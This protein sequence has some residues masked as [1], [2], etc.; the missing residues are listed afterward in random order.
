MLLQC[1]G[2]PCLDLRSVGCKS[3]EAGM[4]TA[5][6]FLGGALR[7]LEETVVFILLQQLLALRGLGV[8]LPPPGV[9]GLGCFPAPENPTG[10]FLQGGRTRNAP[11]A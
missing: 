10:G 9:R 3:P 11:R 5:I 6:L 7:F 8:L 1:R 4:R 2:L